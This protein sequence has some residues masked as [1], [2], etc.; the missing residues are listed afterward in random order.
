ME[1]D[2]IYA[3]NKDIID[4]TSKRLFAV[5]TENMVTAHIENLE[6]KVEEVKVEWFNKNPNLG[7]RI[8]N[9]YNT[10]GLEQN[11]CLDMVE[12]QKLTLYKWGNSKI[13]SIEK[14]GEIIKSVKLQLT[15]EDTNFKKTKVVHWVP[16]RDDLVYKLYNLDH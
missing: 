2:K 13:I 7:E 5:S 9:R 6:D 1:W 8:Q 14:E 12:G 4:N 3:A 11:D 10:L 16:L 15:P